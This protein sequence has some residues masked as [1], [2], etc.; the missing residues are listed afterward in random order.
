MPTGKQWRAWSLP[1]KIGLISL[2]IGLA[3]LLVSLVPI[4]TTE[5]AKERLVSKME[6]LNHDRK[7][8]ELNSLLNEIANR[9]DLRVEFN[10]FKG[11][12]CLYNPT[13]I[14]PPEYYFGR[15]P[16]ETEYYT[17]ALKSILFYGSEMYNGE[18]EARRRYF[19]S[20]SEKFLPD[21]P[22]QPLSYILSFASLED[23]N[24]E[25]ALALLQKFR[26]QYEHV[27]D[28]RKI[29]VTIYAGVGGVARIDWYGQALAT[30]LYANIKLAIAAH[31]LG[32]DSE[33]AEAVR[34]WKTL[35]TYQSGQKLCE[36]WNGNFLPRS[37]AISIS[38]NAGL[39]GAFEYVWGMKF[40]VEQQATALNL[41][42][43]DANST[44]KIYWS[45]P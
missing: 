2:Y 10:F 15:L 41:I 21:K 32:K 11:R 40:I 25:G 23:D 35:N 33:K 14:E 20:I 44:K 4:A 17:R 39:F 38:S 45:V 30:L 1:S 31:N 3:G 27:V 36:N 22:Y 12:L 6:R 19:K 26:S 34:I 9:D 24:Y 43:S 18:K 29:P 42:A 16:A 37:S 13:C 5:P 7:W 28:F 8:S